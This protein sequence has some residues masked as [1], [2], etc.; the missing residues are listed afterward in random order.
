[1]AWYLVTWEMGFEA[2]SYR[3]AAEESRSEQ[4]NPDSEALAFTVQKASTGRKVIIDLHEDD[5]P[6]DPPL[7]QLAEVMNA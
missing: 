5:D 2:D 7:E 4:L 1:M 6:Q 3:E